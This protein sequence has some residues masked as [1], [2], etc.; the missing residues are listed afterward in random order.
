[1]YSTREVVPIMTSS[2]TPSHDGIR[3]SNLQLLVVYLCNNVGVRCYGRGDNPS[4]RRYFEE[5]LRSAIASLRPDTLPELQAL[6]DRIHMLNELSRSFSPSELA[7]VR[8]DATAQAQS[9]VRSVNLPWEMSE[10]CSGILSSVILHNLAVTYIMSGDYSRSRS[11]FRMASDLL[12]LLRSEG[13][14]EEAPQELDDSINYH[15]YQVAGSGE[16]N[17]EN[18]DEHD[19]LRSDLQVIDCNFA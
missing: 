17:G 5:G 13:L 4:A 8:E 2:I 9:P 3:N 10:S 11:L 19:G 18:T 15:L 7:S 6:L 1:M 16:E 14:E 12:Q